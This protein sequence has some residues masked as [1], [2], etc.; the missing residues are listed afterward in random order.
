MQKTA[1]RGLA[2]LVAGYALRPMRIED[3][4]G[5]I[6]LEKKRDN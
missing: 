1:A 3:I 6:S 2:E 4:G 5:D